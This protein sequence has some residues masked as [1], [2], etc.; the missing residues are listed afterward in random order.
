MMAATT[1]RLMQALL[2]A[3][4]TGAHRELLLRQAEMSTATFYRAIESLQSHGLVRE[5]GNHYVLP[6]EHPYNFAFKRLY[7]QGRLLD[8]PAPLRDEIQGIVERLRTVQ[9]G[10]LQALWLHGSVAQGSMNEES[11]LDF[12]AVLSKERELQVQGTREVQMTS[13][14]AQ[15][16]RTAFRDGDPFIRTVLAYGILLLDCD[17]SQE[18]YAQPAPEP[19]SRTWKE[20]QEIQEEID[21][22]VLFFL[23]QKDEGEARRAL[24][25]LAVAVGRSMLD[26]LGELPA[27]KP[28]LLSQLNLYF[29]PAFSTLV[30][31]CLSKAATRTEIMQMRRDLIDWQHRFFIH[32]NHIREVLDKLLGSE[33]RFEV[34]CLDMLKEMFPTQS[35]EISDT[36]ADLR[37]LLGPPAQTVEVFF[38]TF[39]G[40]SPGRL[41]RLAPP[42]T[43]RV[44]LVLNILREVPLSQRAPLPASL[45]HEA[46]KAGVVLVDSRDLFQLYV[47][48]LLDQESELSPD[49][50]L[51]GQIERSVQ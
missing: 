1:Q 20:R 25:S 3:G 37:I 42:S 24:S 38:K 49:R 27:G 15:R 4:P 12:L 7:D 29:G 21:S 16:F 47:R 9:Q 30:D 51:F 45:Y 6:L 31:H 50:I 23:R 8:L 48:K 17:F 40:G 39:L 18:F 14:T 19:G 28:E 22:R 33:K 26:R 34:A 10:N 41:E 43:H 11:D 36:G 32:A 5:Q 46:A 44:L 2:L 35:D 13:F